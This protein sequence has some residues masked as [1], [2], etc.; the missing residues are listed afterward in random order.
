MHNIFADIYHIT[1]ENSM[2]VK[3][4]SIINKKII[5]RIS[6]K[7]TTE[8]ILAH[9]IIHRSKLVNH[10][11]KKTYKNACFFIFIRLTH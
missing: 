5:T 4:I 1:I 9:S 6:E 11:I 10:Y 7:K 3:P 2:I 8:F